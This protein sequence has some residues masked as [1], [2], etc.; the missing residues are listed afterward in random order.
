[1]GVTDDLLA[2]N[3]SFAARYARG[4]V[5]VRPSLCLAIVTRMDSRAPL[6]GNVP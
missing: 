4:H 3:R 1:M 6:C 5:D 2:N